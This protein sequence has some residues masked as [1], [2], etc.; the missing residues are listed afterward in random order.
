[1]R[2]V[3]KT[4]S[5]LTESEISGILTVLNGTFNYWGDRDTFY[6]KYYEN[7][8]GESLHILAYDGTEGVGSVSFW[9]NDIEN[10]RSYQCVD[11]AVLPT[12]RR[13]NIF[14][15][16][17]GVAE[18]YL[19][20]S[21]IYTFPGGYSR[22]G[23]LKLGWSVKRRMRISA[24]LT[25]VILGRHENNQPLPDEFV[26]WR[27]IKHPSTQYY[28]CEMNGRPYLIT[29]RRKNIYAVGGGLSERF[30]L[31][32]VNPWLMLSYDY[33]HIPFCIPGKGGYI[34]ENTCYKT[35]DNSIPSYYAD[36][37]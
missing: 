27:F 28:F 6:W 3:A 23:F 15:K 17:I 20:D 8:F 16:M 12:H 1:M 32:K 7:P 14:S 30:G 29:Q 24:Q 25:K 9:R 4:T 19:D 31:P 5:K 33:L 35:L 26:R 34:L 22:P 37:F 18:R 21:Y 2:Y 10:L 13:K 36:T 11:L